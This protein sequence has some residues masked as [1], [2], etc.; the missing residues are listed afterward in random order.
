MPDKQYCDDIDEQIKVEGAL[1]V[2]HGDVSLVVAA[3]MDVEQTCEKENK[4]DDEPPRDEDAEKLLDFV[5][6]GYEQSL[7]DSGI[8]VRFKH[9]KTDDDE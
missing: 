9:G 2:T 1:S 7:Y 6:V 5:D 3:M 8:Y 4:A